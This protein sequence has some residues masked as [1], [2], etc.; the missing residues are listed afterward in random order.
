MAKGNLS[1]SVDAFAGMVEPLLKWV[2]DIS[3]TDGAKLLQNM[4]RARR[5][6]Q[7]NRG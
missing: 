3:G 7:D 5:R 6:K 2:A 1:R 4:V